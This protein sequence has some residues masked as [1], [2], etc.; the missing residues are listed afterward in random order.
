MVDK[1]LSSIYARP[2]HKLKHKKL[3]KTGNA[4]VSINILTVF[5]KTAG[6]SSRQNHQISEMSSEFCQFAGQY[7]QQK[8]NS[9][10]SDSILE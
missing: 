4:T 6:L 10:R 1:N 7:V 2:W 3:L 5:A 8:I 9:E